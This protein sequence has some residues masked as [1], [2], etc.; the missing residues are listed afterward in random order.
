LD[1]SVAGSTG[2]AE[3]RTSRPARLATVLVVGDHSYDLRA[4][5]ESLL[6]S[7]YAVLV[8]PNS[9][10]ALGVCR[11]PE[12][13]FDVMVTCA[14]RPEMSKVELAA[15]ALALRPDLRLLVLGNPSEAKA[16]T[17]SKLA[18]A[19]QELGCIFSIL[20]RPVVSRELW[21]AIELLRD[22]PAAADAEGRADVR[23]S[24]AKR[25]QKSA[26]VVL[27]DDNSYQR[28]AYADA[29]RRGGH[30]AI[31]L[32]ARGQAVELFDRPLHVDA[33]VVAS[34]LNRTRALELIGEIRSRRAEVRVLLLWEERGCDPPA[35]LGD[36]AEVCVTQKPDSPQ[37]LC[38]GVEELLS[39][40]PVSVSNSGAGGN[41]DAMPFV[42]AVDPL[43][44]GVAA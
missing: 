36:P 7:G 16:G 24:L 25:P 4:V 41:A 26:T 10:A 34:G 2:L 15:R 17:G 30:T 3:I 21:E 37:L 42:A 5:A 33:L 22:R 40:E 43:A 9:L 20:P 8:Q 19:L 29:L 1:P 12:A 31:G 18:A 23:A 44:A 28:R 6:Y 14:T 32:A 27:V 11:V 13:R 39:R 38:E 35:L